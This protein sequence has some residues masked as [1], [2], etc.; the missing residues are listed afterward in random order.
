MVIGITH[1][2]VNMVDVLDKVMFL[3]ETHEEPG[4]L[5]CCTMN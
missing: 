2:V 4:G 5:F 1:T 3:E